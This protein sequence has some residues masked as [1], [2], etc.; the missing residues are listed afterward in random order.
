MPKPGTTRRSAR[1]TRVAAALSRDARTL[2]GEAAQSGSD[3]LPPGG[4]GAPPAV[5]NAKEFGTR[6]DPFSALYWE[7][8]VREL[9]AAGAL[10]WVNHK[11]ERLRVTAKG[12][13][14]GQLRDGPG[15]QAS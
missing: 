7:K 12:N 5:V 6:G 2:L 10:R 14:L 15:R 4:V 11:H 9:V 8:V 13:V 3:V 1:L